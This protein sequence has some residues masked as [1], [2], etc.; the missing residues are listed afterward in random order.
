MVNQIE[1]EAE[2]KVKVHYDDMVR[3]QITVF[4]QTIKI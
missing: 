2:L 3:K 1:G 4:H